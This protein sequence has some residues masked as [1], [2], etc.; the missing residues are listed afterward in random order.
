[1]QAFVEDILT[2]EFVSGSVEVTKLHSLFKTIYKKL[3]YVE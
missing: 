3:V 1:M 2:S